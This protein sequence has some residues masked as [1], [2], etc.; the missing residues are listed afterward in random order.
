M[1]TGDSPATSLVPPSFHN[2]E[3]TKIPVSFLLSLT[4][5]EADSMVRAFLQEP[6]RDADIPGALLHPDA[7][8]P[9]DEFQ[10]AAPVDD[11]FFPWL[12][13]DMYPDLWSDPNSL[14]L[15][16]LGGPKPE[17]IDPA[18]APVVSE[19]EFL[20]HTLIASDP[21]YAGTFDPVLARE[22]FV[23]SNCDTFVS[24][25]FQHTHKHLPLIHRP[26]FSTSGSSSALVLAILL[27]GAVY[28]PPRDTILAIPRF[29]RI[30]E[31]YIFGRLE[32]QLKRARGGLEDAAVD[33]VSLREDM[34]LEMY[35]TLQAAMLIHGA[36]FMMNS[37]G[38]RSRAWVVRKGGLV[39]AIRMLGLT[40][41]RHSQEPGRA[42]DW[43][44]WVRDEM[45]IR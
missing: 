27:C 24:L 8:I 11:L 16:Q 20:H 3:H 37:P 12:Y 42:V 23:T 30:A 44:R 13:G 39:E 25:Y 10:D 17:A 14:H 15:P 34:E 31:Q 4:N 29:F 7:G 6:S 18:L 22:V 43:G 40:K 28:A 33:T 5:P 26:S 38:A 35:E 19:L 36:Q 32:S 45:R 9:A 41:A 2:A 1:T 21:S